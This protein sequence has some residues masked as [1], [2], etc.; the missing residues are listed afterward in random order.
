[1]N[2]FIILTAPS[3]AG[4]TSVLRGVLA[5]VDDLGFCVSATNRPKRAG[6][7][8]GQHYYF[9][10]TEEFEQMVREDA[11]LEW[12]EVYPGRFYG[13]PRAEIERLQALGKDIIFDLD[14]I[15]AKRLQSQ[16]PENTISIFI[17][18]PSL[19]VLIQRLKNRNTESAESFN[20][21]VNR[22]RMELERANEFNHQVLNDSLEQ[23]IHE[24]IA[25]IQQFR[26]KA[27]LPK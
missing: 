5:A 19:D 10:S 25:I 6:E 24:A 11:L 18:P 26:E 8:H 22:M 17:K 15:G 4:K 13:T 16:Y 2:K 23:A 14:V 12:E 3:G 1:M 7:I 21:R 27:D 9:Y 20:M